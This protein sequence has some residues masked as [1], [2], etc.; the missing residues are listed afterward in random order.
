MSLRPRP[1]ETRPGSRLDLVPR[2]GAAEV[3]CGQYGVDFGKNFSGKG[4]KTQA[5]V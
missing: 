3:G 4:K 5:L 2:A 1:P